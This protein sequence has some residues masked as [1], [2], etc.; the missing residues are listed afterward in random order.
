MFSSSIEGPTFADREHSVSK[1][2]WL[3]ELDPPLEFRS[4][5][6][7]AWWSFVSSFPDF[8]NFGA[9]C[10]D[11]RTLTVCQLM[12]FSIKPL[13]HKL[14]AGE[15]KS[16]QVITSARSQRDRISC[17]SMDK[18]PLHLVAE[19]VVDNCRDLPCNLCSFW[20]LGPLARC[21][22]S[23]LFWLGGFPY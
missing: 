3:Q 2:C 14:L 22:F 21:P 4:N 23:P 1:Q 8:L 12:G 16:N 9:F 19:E 17:P 11:V 18:A 20:R 6:G 10:L 5:Q 13:K 7:V 15:Q